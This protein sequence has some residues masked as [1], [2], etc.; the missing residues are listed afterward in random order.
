M[1]KRNG[2]LKRDGSRKGGQAARQTGAPRSRRVVCK[3]PSQKMRRI[4]PVNSFL[5]RDYV[6]L[7]EYNPQVRL[8]REQPCNIRF[9]YGGKV[10][11]CTPDFLVVDRTGARRFVRLK[12]ESWAIAEDDAAFLHAVSCIC[13]EHGL[14]FTLVHEADIRR[15]P[16]LHNIGLLR[17]YSQTEPGMQHRLLCRE[18]LRH[19]P[20]PTLGALIETFRDHDIAC[21]EAVAHALIWHGVISTDLN[22]PLDRQSVIKPAQPAAGGFLGNEVERC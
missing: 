1:A 9:R 13:Q 17:R 2:R 11:V 19:T 20:A 15:Q 6:L 7:M 16:R 4:V 5:A 12:P 3:I 10:R 22:R 8:Y 21:P 18:F 14:E